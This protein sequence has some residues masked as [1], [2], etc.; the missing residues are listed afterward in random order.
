MLMDHNATHLKEPLKIWQ[1]YLNKGLFKIGDSHI[2]QILVLC[3]SHVFL[4]NS[5]LLRELNLK[6][7]VMIPQFQYSQYNSLKAGQGPIQELQL[8]R[9]GR[10][11]ILTGFRTLEG[12]SSAPMVMIPTS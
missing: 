1:K 3:A 2:K 7:L 12:A 8:H 9:C 4:V 6:K 11:C 10:N 5:A